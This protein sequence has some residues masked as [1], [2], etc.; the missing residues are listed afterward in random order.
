M[1]AR[2]SERDFAHVFATGRVRGLPFALAVLACCL[3]ALLALYFSRLQPESRGVGAGNASGSAGPVRIVILVDNNPYGEGLETAWGL[4]ICVETRGA[5]FLFD[6]GPD[7]GVLERN[8]ERLG[9]DLGSLDFVVI[10]HG[11]GD[12]TGGLELAA[13]RRRGLRVYIPRDEGLKRYV[14]SL[15][16]RPIQVNETVEVARGVFVVKP[17]YGPPMEEALAI[18]TSRGLV[19]LVGCSHPGVVNLVRQ[20]ARDVGVKPYMVVGGFH[21][22]GSPAEEAREVVEQLLGM[23]VEKIYPVHC[24]GD[25]VRAYLSESHRGSYGGGV[26]LEIRIEG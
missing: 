22:A 13:L 18:V 26:G 20:A 6:T 2:V 14:E 1:R 5:R 8:A 23:G 4:S 9:V 7:P 19:V 24:S 11:H 3:L 25:A 15:G 10:S 16:L 17:L 21:M 12:H